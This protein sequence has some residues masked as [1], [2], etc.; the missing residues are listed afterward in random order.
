MS[1]EFAI[2]LM[3]CFGGLCLESGDPKLKQ[4]LM[5]AFSDF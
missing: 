1:L 2:R 3:H 4:F 5:D